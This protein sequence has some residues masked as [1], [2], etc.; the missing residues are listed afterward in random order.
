[1]NKC[2]WDWW[3]R[4]MAGQPIDSAPEQQESGPSGLGYGR[5]GYGS[6]SRDLW[7]CVRRPLVKRSMSVASR[8]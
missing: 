1:M 5:S 2:M 7:R 6:A 8:P 4:R 3:G